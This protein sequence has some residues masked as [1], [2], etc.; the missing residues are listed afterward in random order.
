MNRHVTGYVNIENLLN[1]Q[2]NDVLGYPGLRA[3]FRAG[4]RFNL[5]GE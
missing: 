3:N 1:K 2:Y 5:G 4:L